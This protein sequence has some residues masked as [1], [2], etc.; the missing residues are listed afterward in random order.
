M[1]LKILS[2]P[3]LLVLAMAI[4]MTLQGSHLT[5]H[6]QILIVFLIYATLTL[7]IKKASL[8]EKAERKWLSQG[9]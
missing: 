6:H 1:T 5:L 9:H 4:N 8:L 7:K 3:E 2:Q